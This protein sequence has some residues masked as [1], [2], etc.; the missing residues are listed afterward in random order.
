MDRPWNDH[1]DLYEVD[2][3]V[4]TVEITIEKGAKPDDRL[5]LNAHEVIANLGAS[6]VRPGG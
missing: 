6:I 2:R 1:Y 5:A 3:Y 4:A